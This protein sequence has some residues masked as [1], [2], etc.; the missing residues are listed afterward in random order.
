MLPFSPLHILLYKTIPQFSIL[1]MTIKLFPIL[2]KCK[3]CSCEHSFTCLLLHLCTSFPGYTHLGLL[4][5]NRDYK[6]QLYLVLYPKVAVQ[7]YTPTSAVWGLLLFSIHAML[8][9]TS[10][11]SFPHSEAGVVESHFKSNLYFLDYYWDGTPFHVRIFGHIIGHLYFFFC[12]FF[13]WT[14]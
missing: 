2:G 14:L 4:Y 13:Y 5:L 3:R 1:L 7:V 9:P 8:W 6:F 12:P 10:H 11:F